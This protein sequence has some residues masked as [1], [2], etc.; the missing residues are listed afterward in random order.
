[1]VK[2]L[3]ALQET[4]VWFLGWEDPLEKGLTT[5]SSILAWEIPRTEEPGRLQSMGS[6]QVWHD[7]S[8]KQVMSYILKESTLNIHWKHW[9][10]SSNTLAIWCKE[11]TH[12]K[13]PWCWERLKAGGEGDNRGWG[14]WMASPTQMDTSLSKLWEIVKDRE[15]WRAAVHGVTKSW[16]RLNDWTT[17]Y[18]HNKIILSYIKKEWNFAICGNMHGLGG[19][20]AKW[21]VRQRKTNTVW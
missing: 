9:C 5:H 3:P 21:N 2:N 12:W 14:G 7:L 16:T 20:Y 17:T 6:Q 15:A 8:T 18:I 19:H 1:M 10:W 11:P 4:Q 13:R